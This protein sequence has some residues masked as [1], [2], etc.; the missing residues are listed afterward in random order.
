MDMQQKC[1]GQDGVVRAGSLIQHICESGKEIFGGKQ[2]S[3]WSGSAGRSRVEEAR[4]EGERDKS[5]VW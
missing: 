1:G 4:G 3:S 5:V 2:Y